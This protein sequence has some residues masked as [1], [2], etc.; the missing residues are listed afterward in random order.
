VTRITAILLASSALFGCESVHDLVYNFSPCPIDVSYSAANFRDHR[1][2]V[3][4]GNSVGTTGCCGAPRLVDLTVTDSLGNKHVYAA[5]ALA[6]LRPARSVSDRWAYFAD[7]L[8]FLAGS[9]DEIPP[10]KQSDQGCGA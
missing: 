1:V 4:P 8:H 2:H 10:I 7:G 5:D 6:K 9:S 3:L